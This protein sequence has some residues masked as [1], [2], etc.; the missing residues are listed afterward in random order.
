MGSERAEAIANMEAMGFERSQ[1]EAAMRAAFNNPDRAVEYLLTVGSNRISAPYALLL[2]LMERVSQKMFNKS[3]NNAKRLPLLPSQQQLVLKGLKVVAVTM[4]GVLT[5]LIW[6][7]NKEAAP[8]LGAVVEIAKLQLQLLP[9][10]LL[11]K[12]LILET[13]TSFATMLSSSSSDKSFSNNLRCWSRS[14]NNLVLET[15]SSHSS[16]RPILTNSYNY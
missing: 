14:F 3:D 1:I 11:V 13:W 5:S 10:P 2:T 7:L 15:H 12:V 6:L 4:M 16:L 9:P 8:H